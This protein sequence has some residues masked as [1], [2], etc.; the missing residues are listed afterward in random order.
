MEKFKTHNEKQ[1]ECCGTHLQGGVRTDYST[2]VSKFG[3]PHESDG[4]KVDAEWDV[5][6]ADG[7]VA[8]IYNYKTGTNYLGVDGKPV[9]EITTWHI[10]GLSSIVVE[11]ILEILEVTN[12]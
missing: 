8:T 10:G 4:Y 3:Q 6:F 5:E 9:E 12:Q 2:L 11:R 1:I 7:K